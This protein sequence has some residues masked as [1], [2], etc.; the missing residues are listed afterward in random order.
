MVV[1]TDVAGD[2]RE[3]VYREMEG[4]GVSDS[5]GALVMVGVGL[6]PELETDVVFVVA[7]SEVL[8]DTLAG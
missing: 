5:V 3:L 8:L 2:D 7:S 6:Q 1:F 4:C